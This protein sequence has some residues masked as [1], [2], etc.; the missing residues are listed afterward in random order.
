VNYGWAR[1]LSLYQTGLN[2]LRPHPRKCGIVAVEKERPYAVAVYEIDERA[3][4]QSEREWRSHLR[5]LKHCEETGCY[6]AY[7]DGMETI[8]L[9]A[10][11]TDKMEL[12]E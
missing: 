1:Q 5:T 11:A 6:P 10:W 9:P 2:E 7:G 4:E 3:L 8:A 12:G